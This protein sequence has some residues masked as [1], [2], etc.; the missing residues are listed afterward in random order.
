MNADAEDDD[1]IAANQKKNYTFNHF[2]L[3]KPA[4]KQ[5]MK[6]TVSNQM[7]MRKEFITDLLFVNTEAKDSDGENVTTQRLAF[8]HRGADS[9]PRLCFAVASAADVEN[10]N[11]FYKKLPQVYTPP[12][13]FESYPILVQPTQEPQ[14]DKLMVANLA[15]NY[16]QT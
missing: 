2:S 14:S 11:D 1:D 16:H 5:Q 6:V 3:V 15:A 12:S 9:E 7:E 8:I 10:K 13:F 4:K